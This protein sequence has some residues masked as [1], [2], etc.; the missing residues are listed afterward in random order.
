MWSYRNGTY[1]PQNWKTTEIENEIKLIKKLYFEDFHVWDFDTC[2]DNTIYFVFDTGK[3]FRLTYSWWRSYEPD[4][5]D[6]YLQHE[7]EIEEIK[8]EE[9][10]D[11]SS[12]RDWL[13]V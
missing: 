3:Y 4:E 11:I 5:D 13:I 10:K 6:N 7:Y 12:D 1:Y 9:A 8:K 2:G